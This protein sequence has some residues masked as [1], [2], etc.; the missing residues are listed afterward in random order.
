VAGVLGV[1][2]A[3]ALSGAGRRFLSSPSP[4]VS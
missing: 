1:A 4:V 3:L 2:G